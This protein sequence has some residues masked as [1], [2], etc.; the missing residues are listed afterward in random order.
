[1]VLLL[2]LATHVLFCCDG[3]FPVKLDIKLAKRN[4]VVFLRSFGYR[5]SAQRSI[6]LN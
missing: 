6:T 4:V 2:L 5:D 1:M 3:I